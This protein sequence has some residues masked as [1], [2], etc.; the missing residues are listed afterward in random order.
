MC[1]L[2]TTNSERKQIEFWQEWNFHLQET[3]EFCVFF[4]HQSIFRDYSEMML[5]LI[6]IL[7]STVQ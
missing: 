4:L 1:E 5:R 3:V 2:L 6:L 7:C